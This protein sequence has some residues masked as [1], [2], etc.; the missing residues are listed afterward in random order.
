MECHIVLFLSHDGCLGFAFA[1]CRLSCHWLHPP[2][3]PS[4]PRPHHVSCSL[5]LT[6]SLVSSHLL[7]WLLYLHC[8]INQLFAPADSQPSVLLVVWARLLLMDLYYAGAQQPYVY[9]GSGSG[10]SSLGLTSMPKVAPSSWCLGLAFACRP[11]SASPR[12]SCFIGL[13]S[14]EMSWASHYLG[15]LKIGLITPLP[16]SFLF[17]LQSVC[18]TMMKKWFFFRLT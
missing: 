12:L 15:F 11:A 17:S 5:A 10:S 18:T 3:R 6:G 1:C 4:Y 16:L 13:Q 2:R 9:C 8:K 7:R 14:Y